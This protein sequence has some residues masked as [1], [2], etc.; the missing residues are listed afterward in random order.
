MY[1]QFWNF[2]MLFIIY[3]P[4][5]ISL[6][7]FDCIDINNRMTMICNCEKFMIIIGFSILLIRFLYK[8]FG[9]LFDE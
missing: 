6:R 4:I 8:K 9:V 5:V 1:D 2:I 7:C 3:F